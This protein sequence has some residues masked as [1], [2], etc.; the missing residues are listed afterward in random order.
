MKEFN[1]DVPGLA[2][3]LDSGRV[4]D[5][6]GGYFSL[7]AFGDLDVRGGCEDEID[8]DDDLFSQAER[9]EIADHMIARWHEWKV[10]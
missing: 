9:Q 8:D 2:V 10:R 7:S 6:Y 3:K 1:E 5:A 4:I